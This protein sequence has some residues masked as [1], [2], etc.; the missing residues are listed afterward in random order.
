MKYKDYTF[1]KSTND[2]LQGIK[3]ILRLCFGTYPE[4]EGALKNIENRYM[5]AIFDNEIVAMTGILP[6]N[7][8]CFDGYEITWTCTNPKHRHKGLIVNM[9]KECEKELPNDGIPIYCSCWRIKDNKDINMKDV[10]QSLGYEIIDKSY[11]PKNF[12]IKD[13]CGGCIFKESKCYCTE[14]LYC[15]KR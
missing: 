15:K 1:R 12:S 9:Q 4:K 3:S 11:K 6:L 10:M 13:I 8:S 7:R 14:D 2:D 5:L